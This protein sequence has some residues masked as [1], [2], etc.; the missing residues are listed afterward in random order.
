MGIDKYLKLKFAIKQFNPQ[1]NLSF[2]FLIQKYFFHDNPTWNINY[3]KQVFQVQVL[4]VG[5]HTYAWL[6]V[7]AKKEQVKTEL[8]LI[9]LMWNGVAFGIDK[10]EL[11]LCLACGIIL[12]QIWLPKMYI[13]VKFH[14][15]SDFCSILIYNLISNKI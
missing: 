11:T 14:H 7:V 15:L 13:N 12:Q 10:M 1:I 8:E 9:D 4:G 5:T 6:K 3:S 2:N